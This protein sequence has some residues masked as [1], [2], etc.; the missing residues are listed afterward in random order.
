MASP[1]PD[2]QD[3]IQYQTNKIPIWVHI[4]WITFFICSALYLGVFALKD[5]VRWW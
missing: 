5:F 1:K 3:K 4:M 2:D